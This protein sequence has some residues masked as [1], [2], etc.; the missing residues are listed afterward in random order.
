MTLELLGQ[1]PL[2]C[3]KI[4]KGEN[5][6]LEASDFPPFFFYAILVKTMNEVIANDKSRYDF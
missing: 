2:Y 1:H 5:H 6:Y 3:N 4:E